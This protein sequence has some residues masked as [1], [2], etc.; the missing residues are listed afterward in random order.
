LAHSEPNGEYCER[1]VGTGVD[2][3]VWALAAA[4]STSARRTPPP[5]VARTADLLFR[6]LTCKFICILKV[7]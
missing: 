3:A 5:S 6:K 1:G 2:C 4:A 7:I